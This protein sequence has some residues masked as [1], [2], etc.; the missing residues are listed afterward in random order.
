M[1]RTCRSRVL[2]RAGAVLCPL[3]HQCVRYV[4]HLDTRH[5]THARTHFCASTMCSRLARA[6]NYFAG[7]SDSGGSGSGGGAGAL[8]KCCVASH[9]R[10][11]VSLVAAQLSCSNN[12]RSRSRAHKRAAS[13]FGY[14]RRKLC[15]DEI[16]LAGIIG[17]VYWGSG[18]SLALGCSATVSKRNVPS[19]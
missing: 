10:A 19:S 2:V 6:G 15:S 16:I 13:L 11:R 4:I 18:V 7:Q 9:C 17:A 12:W 1:Y 8:P 5:S 3:S 14:C